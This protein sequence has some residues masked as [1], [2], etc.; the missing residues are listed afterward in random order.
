[1]IDRRNATSSWSGYNHQGKVGI[2]LALKELFTLINNHKDYKSYKL[3]LEKNG[4]EDIDISNSTSIVSR[5]QVK[6]KKKGKYPN[7]YTNVRKINSNSCPLGYQISG[8]TNQNRFLHVIC[9]V[10]GWDLDEKGFK[11]LFPQAKY[12]NNESEVQLYKYPDNE[13]FCKLI[14]DND[15]PIDTFCKE[16]IKKILDFSNHPLKD[17][18]EHIEETLFE[19]KNLV[20][21]QISK[22]HDDGKS[23][24]PI[25]N[26]EEIYKIVISQEKRQKQAIRRAKSILEM[27]WNNNVEDDINTTIFNEIL[28]LEDNKFEQLLIDL[29][30]DNYISDLK[31]L[32]NLDNLV[33][34]D[35]FKYILYDFIK[36]CKK[37]KF[38]LS[39]LRYDIAQD[40]FRLSMINAPKHAVI[41]IRQDIM[42]NRE[43]IKASFDTHYLINMNI[44]NVNFF[45]KLPQDDRKNEQIHS[46][47][48]KQ[49]KSIF[50]N[51][52]KFIDIENTLRKLEEDIDG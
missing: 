35:S 51:N 10:S 21:T 2:F 39:S 22:V 27:L 52:L 48:T 12:V 46:L 28:N 14:N 15:S 30:P 37:E 29:H 18:K 43:F 34:K 20:S 3:E 38:T 36:K 50:S 45:E 5:H 23:S 25:I 24:Y 31:S 8:T 13:E 42:K 17:D 33:N 26:F 11:E 47:S 44:H 6:A 49:S 16:F 9:K 4:G 32:N 40:S 7:D 41:C 1:M 19:I